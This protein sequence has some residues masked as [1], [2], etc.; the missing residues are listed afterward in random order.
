MASGDFPRVWELTGKKVCDIIGGH[1]ESAEF[2]PDGTHV[3]T[4]HDN[5]MEAWGLKGGTR[6]IKIWSLEGICKFTMNSSLKLSIHSAKLSQTG[7]R[8]LF[9]HGDGQ[10]T[11]KIV[12]WKK[13]NTANIEV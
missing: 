3:L 6:G 1:I 7:N 10:G 12:L 8:L 2:T 9:T 4:R 13:N 5:N 11:K